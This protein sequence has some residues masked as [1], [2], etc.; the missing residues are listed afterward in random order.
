MPSDTSF[1]ARPFEQPGTPAVLSRRG[2]PGSECGER[3]AL[4]PR[5]VAATPGV[6]MGQGA[7]YTVSV[8]SSLTTPSMVCRKRLP[9]LRGVRELHARGVG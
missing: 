1:T 2:A 7:G 9:E 4:L 5:S 6:T 8:T 3:V